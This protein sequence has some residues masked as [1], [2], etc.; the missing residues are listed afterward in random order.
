MLEYTDTDKFSTSSKFI[1][2]MMWRF[3]RDQKY[4]TNKEISG[5]FL[6]INLTDNSRSQKWGLPKVIKMLERSI[7]PLEKFFYSKQTIVSK[8]KHP[9]FSIDLLF[10]GDNKMKTINSS[11]REKAKTTDVLSFPLYESLRNESQEFLIPGELSLGDIIISR[12]VA[13]RQAKEFSLNIEEEV[14]HLF[15]HGFLHLLG[16][17]HEVSKEEEEI[18]EGLE[19]KILLDIRKS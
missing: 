9:Q 11:F 18:M 2:I 1:Y 13:A 12:D 8:R 5:Q 16:F 6:E 14:I 3:M 7:V 19:K 4:M 15:V 17:D 10:C